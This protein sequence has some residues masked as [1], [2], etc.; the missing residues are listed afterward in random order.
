MS[1]NE[2]T[3]E[4]PWP[5]ATPNGELPEAAK[6]AFDYEKEE[7][8][9]ELPADEPSEKT[10]KTFAPVQILVDINELMT[11][12][13]MEYDEDGPTG[14]P[15]KD[16]RFQIMGMVA[17]QVV[18]QAFSY[19][20]VQEDIKRAINEKLGSIL[21]GELTKSYQ[22][23]GP[24]GQP[25]GQPTTLAEQVAQQMNK[26]LTEVMQATDPRGYDKSGYKG[27]LR[28]FIQ[29]EVGR[30]FTGDLQ[31]TVDQAKA[32]VLE[33]VKE[34]GAEFLAQAFADAAT[35]VNAATPSKVIGE[36]LI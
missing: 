14:N 35:K 20:G 25:A 4:V 24:Y 2:E 28:K 36:R 33:A 7:L 16:I 19:G 22:P 26:F 11:Y 5:R 32:Q 8:P 31:K 23:V 3:N 17:D 30:Q 29:E 10:V 18:K 12:F 21:E 1:D 9:P 27:A 34:K 15:S 6:E 13:G